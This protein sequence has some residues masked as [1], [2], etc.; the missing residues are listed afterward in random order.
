MTEGWRSTKRSSGAAARAMTSMAA[1]TASIIT[2]TWSTMP[3]EV[4]MESREKT[5]SRTMICAITRQNPA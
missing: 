5:A 4:M 1:T 2:E 3:T